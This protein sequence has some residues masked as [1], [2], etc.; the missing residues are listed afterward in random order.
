MKNYSCYLFDADGTLFDTTELICQSY[1]NTAKVAGKAELT[2]DAILKYIGMTLRDQ[3]DIHFGPLSEKMFAHLRSVHMDYQ[4][5]IYK[6]YLKLCSGVYEALKYLTE[7]GSRCVVVT[8]RMRPSLEMYLNDTGI[9]GFFDHLITPETT[10]RHK[11]DPQPAY[12]ALELLQC[13]AQD[14]I[15]IGDSTFDIECGHG[16]GTATAFVNW[17]LNKPGTLK[18]K[19]TYCLD[20]MRD[21]CV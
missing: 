20:D 6:K 17:S 15:F 18:I 11:P 12:K 14:S 10:S 19:P 3:M 13:N 2:R 1:F 8:S 5:S 16:A 7:R 21:L 9:F 4:L